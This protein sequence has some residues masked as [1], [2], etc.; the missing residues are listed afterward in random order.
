[1]SSPSSASV[2]SRTRLVLFVG[3]AL[4]ALKCVWVVWA[5]ERWDVPVAP[6]WVIAPTLAAALL[7]TVLFVRRTP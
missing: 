6:A 2:S 5:V 1:M 3:W 4:I 7:A